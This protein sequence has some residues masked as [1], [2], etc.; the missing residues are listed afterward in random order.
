LF[1]LLPNSKVYVLG[2]VGDGNL[3]FFVQPGSRIENARN[4]SDRAIYE[5][6][7]A[8]HGSISA[9]HGI[10]FEKKAWLSQSR[11]VAEINMMKL[12]KN[13]IDP[14]KILNPG[15]VID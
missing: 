11:T 6:L 9:E 13:T 8:C 12:L 5:P 1:Q 3:H 15:V 2:H 14:R 10:G 7:Q 4:L